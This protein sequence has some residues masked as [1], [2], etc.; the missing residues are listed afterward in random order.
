MRGHKARKQANFKKNFSSKLPP[1]TFADFL[2]QSDDLEF[3][4]EIQ[5]ADGTVFKGQVKK[6]TVDRHGYGT[7]S[8]P[9]G[10]KYE[11][12]WKDGKQHGKGKFYHVDGDMY[13]GMLFGG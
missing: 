4:E 3:R 10:A 1:L 6:G 9:D 5:F 8:W 11:G 12:Y 13:D 2:E 7:Q